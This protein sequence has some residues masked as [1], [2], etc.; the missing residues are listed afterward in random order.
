MKV[1][2]E[3]RNRRGYL[4]EKTDEA[5]CDGRLKPGKKIARKNGVHSGNAGAEGLPRKGVSNT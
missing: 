5:V 3:S 1:S 4:R 2:R